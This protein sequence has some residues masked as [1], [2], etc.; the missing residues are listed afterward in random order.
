M[1]HRYTL[2]VQ[3]A[4]LGCPTVILGFLSLLSANYALA[5]DLVSE[6]RLQAIDVVHKRNIGQ[7]HSLHHEMRATLKQLTRGQGDQEPARQLA[8]Q[9]GAVRQALDTVAATEQ[10]H[11]QWAI[12]WSQRHARLVVLTQ[13]M[14]ALFM[15]ASSSDGKRPLDLLGKKLQQMKEILDIW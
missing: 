11:P 9:L 12:S 15:G 4:L 8:A 14:E 13:E 1:R 5:A 3:I 10:E 6:D 2:P 7:L